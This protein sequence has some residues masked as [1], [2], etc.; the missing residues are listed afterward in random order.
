MGS[1]GRCPEREAGRQ[2]VGVAGRG[3]S[4][5]VVHHQDVPLGPGEVAYAD[6]CLQGWRYYGLDDVWYQRHMVLVGGPLMSVVSAVVC[7]VANRSRRVEAERIAEAQWRPLGNLRVVVTSDRLLVWHRG[8]WSSIDLDV[9]AD[10]R[11]SSRD[12]IDL[13]FASEAPYR[14]AGRGASTVAVALTRRSQRLQSRS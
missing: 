8:T 11:V 9:V 14:L 5:P 1:L 12:D 7:A 13:L 2:V 6:L 3:C 10:F 4:P